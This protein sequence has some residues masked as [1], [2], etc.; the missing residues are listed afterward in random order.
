MRPREHADHRPIGA[1][2]LGAS[3]VLAGDLH[4]LR[5][6]EAQVPHSVGDRSV[7][8]E[9]DPDADRSDRLG[10][11]ERLA[12]VVSHVALRHRQEEVSG[13]DVARADLVREMVGE[14]RVLQRRLRHVD[15]ELEVRVRPQH[16]DG[17][18]HHPPVDV[19]TPAETQRV[20]LELGKGHPLVVRQDEPDEELEALQRRKAGTHRPQRFTDGD[21]RAR[22]DR[23]REGRGPFRHL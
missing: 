14:G 11:R 17:E 2:L 9:A 12:D 7:F 6:D 23:D 3:D 5:S 16:A 22:L 4:P 15:L 13:I 10:E 20:R 18:R 21:V 19:G 1:V 8:V